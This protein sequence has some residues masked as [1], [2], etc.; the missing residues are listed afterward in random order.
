VND[1]SEFCTDGCE[2]CRS[3]VIRTYRELRLSG[4]D[5]GSAYRAALHVLALRHPER[6]REECALLASQWLAPAGERRT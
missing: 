4:S 3:A 2:T 5:E 6:S 1:D